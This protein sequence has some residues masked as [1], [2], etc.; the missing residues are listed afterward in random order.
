MIIPGDILSSL[1][2][3]TKG[4]N[5]FCVDRKWK[6]NCLS[7]KGGC[8]MIKGNIRQIKWGLV[9]RL[10]LVFRQNFIRLEN[11]YLRLFAFSIMENLKKC[12]VSLLARSLNKRCRGKSFIGSAW[13][14]EWEFAL[15]S[16][17]F[18]R[19]LNLFH[20]RSSKELRTF[21]LLR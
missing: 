4:R 10:R 18:S 1:L 14:I 2:C 5:S 15:S 13:K 17:K 7:R 3:T 9:L 11:N 20:P 12:F 21:N 8:K 19:L 16:S 6:W